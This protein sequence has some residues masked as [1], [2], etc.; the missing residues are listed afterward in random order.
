MVV[1]TD[2]SVKRKCYL[3]NKD[4]YDKANKEWYE[5]NPISYLLVCAKRRAKKKGLEFSIKKEDVFL[6]DLCPVFNV[7]MIKGTIMAPSLDRI[8]SSKGYVKDNVQV[9]STLANRM[10][11]NA[12]QEELE[13][14][15]KW[16]LKT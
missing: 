6:P 10:K 4:K 9:I 16:I 8:D 13:K 15:A 12:T 11:S 5:N 3:R 7:P 2:V 14:F 1:S